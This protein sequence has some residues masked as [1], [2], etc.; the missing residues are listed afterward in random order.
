MTCFEKNCHPERS[1]GSIIRH[2]SSLVK[3]ANRSFVPQDDKPFK[4]AILFQSMGI[5]YLAMTARFIF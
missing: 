5:L 2:A 1:E 3:S 4:T